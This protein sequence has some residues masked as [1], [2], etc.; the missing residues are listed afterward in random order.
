M[1][2]GKTDQLQQLEKNL[3][4]LKVLDRNNGTMIKEYR[5]AIKFAINLMEN[6]KKRLR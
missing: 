1:I 5:D 2:L 3:H 6:F 4:Y